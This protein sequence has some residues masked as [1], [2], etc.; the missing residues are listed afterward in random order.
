MLVFASFLDRF[1]KPFWLV[2]GSTFGALGCQKVTKMSS[3]ID[4]KF[5]IEHKEVPRTSDREIT[6]WEKKK[7]RKVEK[8]EERK[9]GTFEDRRYLPV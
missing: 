2:L 1:W 3:Q 9:T 7:G 4:S 6:S 8:K 5:Y